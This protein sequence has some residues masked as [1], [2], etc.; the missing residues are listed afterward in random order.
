MLCFPALPTFGQ[1]GVSSLSVGAAR[2]GYS[3]TTESGRYRLPPPKF[4]RV[5][6]FVNYHRHQI[7]LPEQGTRVGLSLKQF[8]KSARRRILQIGIAT[9]RAI[10]PELVP[11]L[12]VCLV[13]DQSGSMS[14]PRIANVKKAVSELAK[15]FR[16]QDRISIVGFSDRAAVHLESCSSDE[17]DRIARAVERLRADGSTNLHAGLK[18]G[19]ETAMKHYSAERTNRVI[20]L[21]DGRANTGVTDPHQISCDALEFIREGVSLSTIGLGANF[22]HDLL[23]ELADA[24]RGLVHFVDDAKDIEKTFVHEVDSLLA[25]AASNVLVSVDLGGVCRTRLIGYETAKKPTGQGFSV[26]LDDLNHGAT[27]VL[28]V[29][30]DGPEAEISVQLSY[31]DKITGQDVTLS[32]EESLNDIGSDC[33]TVRRNYAIALVAGALKEAS[34]HSNQGNCQAAQRCLQEGI[35]RA[36]ET[37]QGETDQEVERVTKIAT[38]YR[39]KILDCIERFGD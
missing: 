11:P 36:R 35:N 30:V 26:K 3:R 38:D 7:P 15:R 28:L 27:Q 1:A 2:S 18:L 4:F 5:E 23:R 32:Q 24:G 6:E 8:A 9:P 14:G 33:W 37:V 12:N 19:F 13:I 34:R 20:L 39:H 25:P 31:R 10:D 29:E 17:P 22:N 16:P 21:T